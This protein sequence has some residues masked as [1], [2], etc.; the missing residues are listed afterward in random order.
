[1]TSTERP[2][3]PNV[4]YEVAAAQLTEQIQRIDSLDAKLSTILSAGSIALPLVAALLAMS[5]HNGSGWTMAVLG[6]SIYVYLSLFTLVLQGYHV[7]GWSYG[8]KIEALREDCLTNSDS[9]MRI[10]IGEE[11]MCS[12][13]KNRDLFT[14]K[15]Q[16]LTWAMVFL[17]VESLLLVVAVILIPGWV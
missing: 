15:E 16:Y 4:F 12:I 9:A 5:P 6:A 10:S 1:M 3:A 11:F 14:E 17:A 2:S 8:S 7:Q 13:V